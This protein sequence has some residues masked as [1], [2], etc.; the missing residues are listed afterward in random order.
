MVDKKAEI[1]KAG[2]ELFLLKGFKDV[3][4]S[5]ITREAGVG[6]GTFYNY[7]QSK[8]ELFFDVYFRENEAAKKSIVRSLDLNDD[9]ITLVTK[10]L[11]LSTGAIKKNRILQEWYNKDIFGD[12]EKRYND[13]YGC[14][15]FD[16]YMDLL[17]KWKRENKIRSD[18][19][20]ELLVALMNSVIYL[21]THKE[22]IGIQ[23]FPEVTKLLVKF[24]MKGLTD[25]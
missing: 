6:V 8:G 1:F 18:I 23:Y 25:R 20:D 9:P 4:V 3:N 10:F 2:R 13:K 24:I 5:D 21:D 19:D 16:F 7:Y 17:K 15:L 11:S 12:L 14:F 22:E